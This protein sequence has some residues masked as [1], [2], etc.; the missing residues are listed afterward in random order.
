MTGQSGPHPAA[1]W[2]LAGCSSY[3]FGSHSAIP[4]APPLD[5]PKPAPPPPT[6]ASPCQMHDPNNLMRTSGFVSVQHRVDSGM[7]SG[8]G[9]G[10]RRPAL[11]V[12]G[13]C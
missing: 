4:L 9:P 10:M 13:S 2:G 3:S 6:R 1:C 5:P 11:A 8:A 7:V 12:W